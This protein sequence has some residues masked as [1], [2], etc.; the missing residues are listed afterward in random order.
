[1]QKFTRMITVGLVLASPSFLS[2]GAQTMGTNPRP[3]VATSLPEQLDWLETLMA[4]YV[5][6]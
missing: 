3:R 6:L 5:G 4:I 2:L 1:M